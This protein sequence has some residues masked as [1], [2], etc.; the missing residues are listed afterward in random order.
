MADNINT[1]ILRVLNEGEHYGLDIIKRISEISQD[2]EIKQPSLYS[3][4]RRLEEKGFVE[5]YWEDGVEGGRR[6]YYKIT[7]M[8]ED[9]LKL[10]SNMEEFQK[11]RNED[12][13]MQEQNEIDKDNITTENDDTPP[14]DIEDELSPSQQNDENDNIFS[15]ILSNKSDE[16]NAFDFDQGSS[17]EIA[18]FN[19]YEE[20]NDDIEPKVEQDPEPEIPD[21]FTFNEDNPIENDSDS[22]IVPVNNE[23]VYPNF[24]QNEK[25]IPNDS[26]F[27]ETLEEKKFDDIDYKDILG[28]L[29]A[30][31][32]DDFEENRTKI[33]ESSIS[34]MPA[35]NKAPPSP[36][37]EPEPQKSRHTKYTK[38]VAEIFSK[39]QTKASSQVPASPTFGVK[40]K[41][42]ESKLVSKEKNALEELALKYNSEGKLP[43]KRTLNPLEKLV[44]KDV[45]YSHIKQDD[46][47]IRPYNKKSFSRINTKK[48]VL[49]SQFNIFKAVL[50]SILLCFELVLCYQTCQDRNMYAPIH[51]YFYIICGS[52]GLVY[53]L[54]NCVI[55]AKDIN[56]KISVDNLH[57]WQNLGLRTVFAILLVAFSIGMCFCFGMTEFFE[58]NYFIAWLLP[59]II[60]V[61]IIFSWLLALL[62][63]LIKLFRA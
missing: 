52:L 63:H 23:V 58:T 20:E 35:I 61:D 60:A 40:N 12:F 14:F 8:G 62:M 5:S 24:V 46:V 48:F 25:V 50:L 55:S 32:F 57:L 17:A 13:S 19:P 27:K 53:L 3:A 59:A 2:N 9:E 43:S 30:D 47:R 26:T 38:Q 36:A 45:G 29:E 16:T 7:P 42:I 10:E 41:E 44:S 51:D 22:P 34:S 6:H 15:N 28:D 39:K 33:I 21:S 56:K 1:L 11:N 37:V 4:L 18:N 49:T 54:L 31:S